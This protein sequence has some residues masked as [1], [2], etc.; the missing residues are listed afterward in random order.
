MDHYIDIKIIPDRE[1]RENLLM[2]K[3]YTKLHKALFNLESNRIGVSFPK[4]KVMFGPVLR[5]HSTKENLELLQKSNWLGGLIGYCSGGEIIPIPERPQYRIISRV[6][7]TMSQSKLKRL[8]KRGSI[9][10]S[11]VKIYK[12][13]MFSKG[14]DNPYLEL[15][16]TSN[17]HK[18]RRYIQFGELTDKSTEGV[19]DDFG[20]SKIATVPWF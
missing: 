6:Q 12:A 15:E 5:L 14:L 19:F 17:G 11:E 9:T 8:I 20:L 2:N 10:E 7:S 18:H 4:W 3:V 16:S 1:M 13:K